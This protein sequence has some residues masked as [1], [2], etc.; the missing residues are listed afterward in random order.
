[1]ITSLWR[2]VRAIH[3]ISA[4]CGPMGA[5]NLREAGAFNV[6]TTI[7]VKFLALVGSFSLVLI[8]L[9]YLLAAL[10]GQYAGSSSPRF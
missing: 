7:D 4:S 10:F 2:R 5:P 8:V 6:Y 3:D 9:S 1:M